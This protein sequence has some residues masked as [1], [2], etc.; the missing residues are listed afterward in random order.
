VLGRCAA[1]ADVAATLIAN[2]V[3]LPA[4]PAITRCP[5]RDLDPDSDLGMQPVVTGCA[6]LSPE[7]VARALGQ[8]AKRAEAMFHRGRIHAAALFLGG[9]C[10][11]FGPALHP[12]TRSL[13]DA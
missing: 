8:G 13:T 5:A 11:T 1:E 4:H 10:H 7:E 3:D 9:V 6:P 12:T 2:A